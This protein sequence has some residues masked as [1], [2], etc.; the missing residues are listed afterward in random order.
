M[1]GAA[2]GLLVVFSGAAWA[3][4]SGSMDEAERRAQ[5][6]YQTMMSPFCPGRTIDACP[7]PYA[8]EWREDIRR[9]TREGVPTEEIRRRLRERMPDKDLTGAPST[10]MDAV[11][12]Y[13]VSALA[14]VLL[15]LLLWK[16]LRQPQRRS[17]ASERPPE[18][19]LDDKEL[20]ARLER[21]LQGL[22]D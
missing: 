17:D 9:W 13:F 2:F 15:G 14:L 21:E 1:V 3:Q 5:D 6:I 20:D 4:T 8:A 10:A 18:R 19:K 12:P 16:L 7:S 22:E 11:L